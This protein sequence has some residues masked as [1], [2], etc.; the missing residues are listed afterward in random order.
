MSPVGNKEEKQ[1]EEEEEEKEEEEEWE[2]Q[3]IDL[4]TSVVSSRAVA[5]VRSVFF[6][7]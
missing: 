6:F 5:R 2:K 7:F 4:N 3:K 1:E